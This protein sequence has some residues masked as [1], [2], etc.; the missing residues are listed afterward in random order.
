MIVCLVDYKLL[1]CSNTGE[2][3][4]AKAW[5]TSYQISKPLYDAVSLNGMILLPFL[6][7]GVLSES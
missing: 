4:W 5:I 2:L 6:R 3:P 7:I 1:D